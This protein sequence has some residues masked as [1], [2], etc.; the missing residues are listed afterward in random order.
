MSL[1]RTV[2]DTEELSW[3]MGRPW[4]GM[5]ELTYKCC[6]LSTAC[7]CRLQ[8]SFLMY[9]HKFAK[10]R[11]GY[12]TIPC[13]LHQSV[14]SPLAHSKIMQLLR[15]E[16]TS[17]SQLVKAGLNSKLNQVAQSHIQS[18]FK[19]LSVWR[20]HNLLGQ[21][22]PVFNNFLGDVPHCHLISSQHFQFCNLSLLSLFFFS[23][24]IYK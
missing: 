7:A 13:G 22:F 2:T 5:S 4:L 19:Y 11:L 18:N 3:H 24:G 6:A 21:P 12:E 9:T 23:F 1:G 20:F 15:L 8:I 14:P 17:G 10:T 16:R